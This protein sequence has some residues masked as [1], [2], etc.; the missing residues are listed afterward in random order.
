MKKFILFTFV[1]VIFTP[2]LYASD[3]SG[4]WT[5]QGAIQWNDQQGIESGLCSNSTLDLSVTS[6]ELIIKTLHLECDGFWS[7]YTEKIQINGDVLSYKGISVGFITDKLISFNYKTDLFSENFKLELMNAK[8]M[9]LVH[10]RFETV[11]SGDNDS[12]IREI[13]HDLTFQNL[14]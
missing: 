9:S 12:Y 5:G 10:Q 1:S 6:N 11:N 7:Y 2:F 8:E 3:F 4:T 13:N 14:H